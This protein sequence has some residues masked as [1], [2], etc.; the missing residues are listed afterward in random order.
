MK[1]PTK[2]EKKS[3]WSKIFGDLDIG[4]W[5]PWSYCNKRHEYAKSLCKDILGLGELHNKQLEEHYQGK[6]WICSDR[7]K[8]DKDGTDP[9]PAA[10]VAILLSPRVADRVLGQGCVGSRIVWVRIAGPVCNLFIIVVYI[11]H[12]GR[13]KAPFTQDTLAKVTELMKTIKKGDCT[14]WMGDL[15]CEL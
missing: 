5:N 6:R 7:S 8:L 12:R 1:K 2:N 10:G 15:N 14:I 13:T 11:P 4:F 3:K 9:D